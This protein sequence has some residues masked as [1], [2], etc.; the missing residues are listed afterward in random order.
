MGQIT[1][2]RNRPTKIHPPFDKDEKAFQCGTIIFPINGAGVIG[3]P[4]G[5]RA[6]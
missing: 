6:T 5:F 3:N 2:Y 1:E 4:L